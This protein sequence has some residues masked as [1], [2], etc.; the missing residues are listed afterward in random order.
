MYFLYGAIIAIVIHYGFKFGSVLF[1]SNDNIKYKELFTAVIRNDREYLQANCN[2]INAER[3]E[4]VLNCIVAG[5]IFFY[6]CI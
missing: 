6:V 1:W 3:M 2:F 4:A 5:I